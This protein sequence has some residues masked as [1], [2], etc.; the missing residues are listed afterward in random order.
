M[1]VKI[2]EK[3][4]GSGVWWVFVNHDGERSSILIG[5]QR[6]ANRAKEDLE[7]KLALG[8]PILPE[9]IE[10]PKLTLEAYYRKFERT[11]LKTACRESTA[12]RYD[13]CFRI[14]ILPKF[15]S[16]SLPEVTREGVKELVADL[17]EKKLAKP[18]I[19]IITANLCTVLSHAIEDKL[20]T[21]NPA[22]KLSRFY[23]QAP[24]RHEMIEPLT[25][26]EVEKFLATARQHDSQKR[27]KDIPDYFPLF[28]CAIHTGMRAGELAGL[29]WSD[30]DWNG[31][32]L[33]V[34]RSIDKKGNVHPT[35]TGKIHR[36]DM[37]DALAAELVDL[38]RRRKEEYL[39]RGKNEIPDWTFCNSDGGL[40]D[41]QNLK[42]RHFFKCLEKAKLHR[43]R[44]HDLRHTF[45]S[46]LL[47][48]GESP[49]YVKEQLGHSSIKMTVD[50]YGHLIPGA[51]RQAVNRLPFPGKVD[52]ENAQAQAKA[53]ER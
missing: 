24:I 35:K 8:L 36:I 43:I 46:L 23:K 47:Q 28:L 19:R 48:N 9:R 31:K 45:A 50:I 17:V 32:F 11:Y 6:A 52:F 7:H 3:V 16:L 18:T 44:F 41:I 30:I 25:T 38:R 22:T 10:E 39:G 26:G 12:E 33:V 15:G 21:Y 5:S 51:N 1:G 40:I 4:K 34:R 14:H 2:R 29:Q 13:G 37:S 49:V 53:E 20:I 42:N 27:Y